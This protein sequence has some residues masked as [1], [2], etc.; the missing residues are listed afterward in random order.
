V[1]ASQA[2]ASE[3]LRD[4]PPPYRTVVFDCDS[5]LCAIEGIDELAR[6][7]LTGA[8]LVELEVLTDR[9]MAGELPLEAVFGA[10]LA[11]VRPSRADLE[12]VGRR[13]VASLMP[14][15]VQLIAELRERGVAVLVLSGG[16][17]PAVREAGLAVGLA[18][19][20]IHA[21]DVRFDERGE[22][23]DFDSASPLARAG[24]KLELLR[25]LGGRDRLGPIALVGDGA[26]DLEAAP[27]LDR[28]IAYGGVV[29]RATVFDRAR[30]GCDAPDFSALRPL[31][32]PP[33]P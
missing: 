31:L 18:S 5:T 6:A 7:C 19:E 12:E 14:G 30:V 17:L 22:Y 15:A 4:A 2:S 27:E 25:A 24:G 10:R 11:M 32:L 8:D 9:A 26:T 3:R 28:F 20:D 29:R 23:L 21:V 13:Y 1:S 16:L 33:T